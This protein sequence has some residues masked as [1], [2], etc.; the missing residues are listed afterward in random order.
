MEC[1]TVIQFISQIKSKKMC[2][3]RVSIATSHLTTRQ[4]TDSTDLSAVSQSTIRRR[5]VERN[6][7][8]S[9]ISG[10]RPI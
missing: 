3:A 8:N 1:Y 7:M 6:S 2:K 5:I 9:I 4:G 10:I